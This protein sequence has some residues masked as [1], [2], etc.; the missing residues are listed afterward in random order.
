[1]EIRMA[2]TAFFPR[3]HAMIVCDAIERIAGDEGQYNLLGVR[4]RITPTR[5]PYSHP[6]LGVYLQ[7]SGRYGTV[8]INLK[9]VE[10]ATDSVMAVTPERRIEL[11]GPL[12]LLPSKWRINRCRFP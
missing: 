11:R 8:S 5:Y 10:A 2:E 7:I 3:V 6:R 4:T 12:T 1:M 9:V